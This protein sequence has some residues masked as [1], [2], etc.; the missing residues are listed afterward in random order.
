MSSHPLEVAVD[1]S[2][3]LDPSVVQVPGGA[4]ARIR[5]DCPSG[6]DAL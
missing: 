6:G 5:P 2:T 1:I 3:Q 4:G